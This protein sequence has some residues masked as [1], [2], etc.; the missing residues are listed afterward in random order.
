MQK[1]KLEP[2]RKLEKSRNKPKI[3]K[4]SYTSHGST[5]TSR[6]RHNSPS[7]NITINAPVSNISVTKTP[8]RKENKLDM[9]YKAIPSA[10][11]PCNFLNYTSFF[12]QQDRPTKVRIKSVQKSRNMQNVTAP[13]MMVSPTPKKKQANFEKPIIKFDLIHFDKVHGKKM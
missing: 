13:I 1:P 3:P 6:M 9:T 12:K 8:H 11:T 5:S 10:I 2:I 7:I 4:I